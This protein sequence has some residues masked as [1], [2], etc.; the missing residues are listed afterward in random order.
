MILLIVVAF[1]AMFMVV[2]TTYLL[3]ADSIRRTSEFDLNATD[4]RS[5]FALMPDIDPRYIFN[6]ALGQIIYDVSDPN[7]ALG[8]VSTNSALRGHSLARNIYSGYDSNLLNDKQFSGTGKLNKQ[9]TLNG[10][11]LEEWKIVNMAFPVTGKDQSSP[12]KPKTFMLA[13]ERVKFD[14]NDGLFVDNGYPYSKTSSWNA[15]YTYPDHNNFYLGWLSSDGTQVIP[16]FHRGDIFGSMKP[17]DFITP[18]PVPPNNPNWT[19][20]QGKY[21]TPRPRPFDHQ[22][23]PYPEADGMDVKNLEG[24]PGGNDSIWID[25]GFPVMTT[26]DGRKYKTLIAPLIL[27]LDGRIN[28]N[29]AGNTMA[30]GNHASNQGWGPWEINVSKILGD[31]VLGDN[32][33]EAKQINMG[34]S[35]GGNLRLPGV[36]GTSLQPGGSTLPTLDTNSPWGTNAPTPHPYLTPTYAKVDFTSGVAGGPILPPTA[37]S[38]SSFPLFPANYNSDVV[39]NVLTPAAH[40]SLVNPQRTKTGNSKFN[41]N[42][43]A[44]LIRW[45][46]QGSAPKAT[47]LINLLKDSLGAEKVYDNST[48]A[49]RNRITTLS[50]DIQQSS[51]LPLNLPTPPT[52]VSAIVG[53]L[54]Q[55]NL[56]KTL[57]NYP[58]PNYIFGVNGRGGKYAND[59]DL[60]IKKAND[61]RQKFAEELFNG[62]KLATGVVATDLEANRYL[63]Q[64]AVN[65]VDY[66]DK[67]DVMT[68]FIWKTGE[69]VYGVELPKVVINEVYAEI[70]NNKDDKFPVVDVNGIKTNPASVD[71][72]V[73]FWVELM[74]PLP[75]A[76]IANANTAVLEQDPIIMAGD[77][78]VYQLEIVDKIGSDDV[79]KVD[80]PLGLTRIKSMNIIFQPLVG[81]SGINL[82]PPPLP[83]PAGTNYLGTEGSANGFVVIGSDRD[84]PNEMAMP[85]DMRP[86]YSDITKI[87]NIKT[88]KLKYSIPKATGGYDKANLVTTININNNK[89]SIILRRLA[90]PYLPPNDFVPM[91]VNLAYPNLPFNP[92]IAVDVMTEIT[93]NDGVKYANDDKKADPPRFLNRSSVVRQQ[94]YQDTNKKNVNGL[95]TPLVKQPQHTFLRHNGTT[96]TPPAGPDGLLNLPFT[97]M[98]HLDRNLINPLELLQVCGCK[99]QELT[100]RFGNDN[101]KHPNNKVFY[102]KVPWFDESKNLYRFFELVGTQ[103]YQQG[104]AF[105]GRQIGK[106][107]I[108]NV[109]DKEVFSALADVG[110]N[111]NFTQIDV[112]GVFA[113]NG[114]V[115]GVF[116]KFKNQ[117]SPNGIPSS[118]DKPLWGFGVGNSNGGDNWTLNPRGINNS[119]FLLGTDGNQV[120][121][122]NPPNP[123]NIVPAP[124]YNP[125][126]SNSKELLS[127]I[128]NNVTTRSNVFAIWITT[129]YFEVTNDTTQPPTLGAEMGKADGINI[130]HRMFAIVDRTNMVTGT[131]Q[132]NNYSFNVGTVSLFYLDPMTNML[133]PKFT[134]KNV[135]NGSNLSLSDGMILTFEPNSDNEE[136]VMLRLYN[137]TNNPMD[138]LN[139]HLV[140]NFQKTHP[141]NCTIINRGNPGPWIGYD[142]MKDKDVVIYSE[143]IE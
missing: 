51:L 25:A 33:T 107:N 114:L 7:P 106:V 141:V 38:F 39:T 78:S 31:N 118:G 13:P 54:G 89:P 120:F 99:P 95:V 14:I 76:D 65:I 127:K 21:L 37:T 40:A 96:V 64:L 85:D 46:G 48:V 115:D 86:P 94:P 108:N 34:Y 63:A 53:Y 36:Y 56:N 122:V 74:N 109:W 27:D 105:A 140:A 91:T 28:L 8:S 42:E 81:I 66:I 128:Y 12:P 121:N 110:N 75:I 139:G 87:A 6:I 73:H 16:S 5:D 124:T 52:A 69:T 70:M 29:V 59:N 9:V 129:G 35:A 26:P 84:F 47:N 98:T 135:A 18:N 113:E 112:D 92:Y 80:N 116:T 2:G 77:S 117:R 67:D 22:G 72:E 50:A 68:E 137:N 102:H 132:T 142:R 125:Y 126:D 55:I 90:N 45:S 30:N 15:P 83:P 134:L 88:D 97:I 4:K 57:T 131:G 23:F 71:F 10:Q 44:S 101:Y 58:I 11:N 79:L 49:I 100:Q 130:R 62:L 123:T 61:E 1:L 104:T 19:N 20:P 103:G 138:P 143:I 119:L 136:T 32:V 133:R 3:V 43:M 17:P 82:L 41:P 24:Y 111:N 93:V 60:D